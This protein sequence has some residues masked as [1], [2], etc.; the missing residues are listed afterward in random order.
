MDVVVR[1][2][3]GDADIT[4]V[5]APAT[6]TLG[7]LLVAVSGQTAPPVARVD[8]RLVDTGDP[9]STSE[10]A[11]G[12]VIDARPVGADTATSRTIDATANL[13]QLTGRGAGS[14]LHLAPGRY[15][16]GAGR[17]LNADELLEAPVEYPAFEID[18]GRDGIVL[19]P[20]PRIGGPH[21]VLT[22]T[23][24]DELFDRELSWTSGRLSVAG[25]VF[26]LE[27]PPLDEPRRALPAPDAR[28]AV[29]FRR[30]LDPSTPGGELIAVSARRRARTADGGL[31]SR[32]RADPGAYVIPLGLHPDGRENVTVD[33]TRHSGIAFVGS[34]RFGTGLTR[35]LLVG[36]LTMHG[37]SDLRVTIASTPER[38][39]RWDWAKWFPHL[40]GGDPNARPSLIADPADLATWSEALTGAGDAAELP[41]GG[42]ETTDTTGHDAKADTRDRTAAADR[43]TATLEAPVPATTADTAATDPGSGNGG[44]SDAPG[45]GE[46]VTVPAELGRPVVHHERAGATLDLLVLDEPSLWSRRDSPLRDLLVDPPPDLRIVALCDSIHEAPGVC[47]ALVEE[48]T[49]ADFFDTADA[50]P[51]NGLGAE[52]VGSPTLFGSLASMHVRL[53]PSSKTV[54]EIRP[55]LVT[56]EVASEVA[57]SIAALDDLDV[58]RPAPPP[59]RLAPPSLT[60][61]VDLHTAGARSDD[62]GGILVAVGLIDGDDAASGPRARRRRLA[63]VDVSATR[64]VVMTAA[65]QETRETLAAATILGATALRRTDQLA[66]LTVSARRPDWHDDVP[67]I[68]GHVDATVAED[69]A[70]PIHRVA[71]VI[72]THPG[73]EVLVV[74]EDA[75]TAPPAGQLSAPAPLGLVTGMLELAASL[76]NVHVVMTTAHPPDQLPRS[77]MQKCGAVVELDGTAQE[78][79]G[80]VR[81]GQTVRDVAGPVMRRDLATTVTDTGSAD[82]LRVRSFVFGRAMT[83]LERRLDR[84]EPAHATTGGHDPS[85]RRLAQ[86][87]GAD[88]ERS[89]PSDDLLPPP[90]V[91]SV[92]HETL[93]EQ[94]PGGVPLGLIDRPEHADA[95]AYRWQPGPGGSVLAIGAPRSGMTNLTDLVTVGIA[96]R[97]DAN[98]LHLYAVEPL[99]QRR[100]AIRSLPHTALVVTTDEPAAARRTIATVADIVEERRH[101]AGRADEPTVVLL[102]GDLARLRRALPG[103]AEQDTLEMLATIGG[104]GPGLGVNLVCLASRVDDIGPLARI[105]GD[106]LVGTLSDPS[107]YT[108]LGVPPPGPG[109]RQRGRCWSTVAERRV[110][111]ATPPPSVDDALSAIAPRPATVRSGGR[112]PATGDRVEGGDRP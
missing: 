2:P 107:D 21:G 79:R 73:L 94:H 85:T 44:A 106:R 42:D 16:I 81:T 74:I 80:S 1:T 31:W 108:R 41:A 52:S 64:V 104:D 56:A 35:T 112:P 82:A 68:A 54:T 77:V 26:Q 7:D 27:S 98:D 25:R 48:R 88:A 100:R 5:S 9:L 32:R 47:T 90:L 69:P 58:V 20:G 36:A 111:L 83:P 4:I 37:P 62:H 63:H 102:V 70:R 49:P 75:F 11:V 105:G 89:A 76:P 103:D 18:V 19:R 84:D 24:D 72:T 39:G 60:E 59:T 92:E 87:I 71:H 12:S 97:T 10:L 3:H 93:L 55:S 23:L 15:R 38:L 50:T 78:P 46:R 43:A 67:H 17:R 28:G 57:A 14:I 13:L 96:A 66:V 53:G 45:S 95:V 101:R 33:F 110:Q 65:E 22:P 91:A 51:A 86:R 30:P 99:P 61:L 6:S 109:D 34:D 29:A 8:G 40:R